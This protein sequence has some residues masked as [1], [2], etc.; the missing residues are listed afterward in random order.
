M[1]SGHVFNFP[2]RL[3]SVAIAIGLLVGG[4]KELSNDPPTKYGNLMVNIKDIQAQMGITP[5]S[6]AARQ[7][8]EPQPS[9]SVPQE[10]EASDAVR[11]LLVGAFV[12]TTRDTPYTRD[13]A[14]TPDI[15]E[16]LQEEL[17]GSVDYI[18]I[19]DLPTD[20]DYVEF[21][22]PKSDLSKWQVIAVGLNFAIKEFGELGEEAHEDAIIYAGFSDR[23][24]RASQIE[25]DETVTVSMFRAC[26]TNPVKGCATYSDDLED[27]PVVVPA[28]EILGVRYNDQTSDF[29]SSVPFP[30]LV[31]TDADAASAKQKLKTVVTEIQNT[32]ADIDSL[33]VRATHTMNTAYESA[34]C[35][36]LKDNES[37]TVAQLETACQ[38]TS[39]KITMA[40]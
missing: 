18:E 37:A 9:V 33:T 5:V 20:E 17:S 39:S 13:V 35:Q 2:I 21:S 22:Y 3:I 40:E 36:A 24:Y 26:L 29:T 12:V 10:T 8:G 31:R 27:D 19:V 6:D 38:V 23:F 7:A 34:A 30:L 25:E 1:K 4:C 32:G 15:E 11:S 28:V 14:L 16:N